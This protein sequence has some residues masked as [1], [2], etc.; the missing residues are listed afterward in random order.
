MFEDQET[1]L[2]T[3]EKVVNSM[4]RIVTKKVMIDGIESAWTEGP[5]RSFILF[6]VDHERHTI[7]FD[8]EGRDVPAEDFWDLCLS[9]PD[10]REEIKWAIF[11]SH[12]VHPAAIT[13]YHGES[14]CEDYRVRVFHCSESN[15]K[16]FNGKVYNNLHVS[17]A[18]KITP[19][20]EWWAG[21]LALVLF[22]MHKFKLT[23]NC[24]LYEDGD[25]IRFYGKYIKLISNP[26]EIYENVTDILDIM[27]SSSSSAR[28]SIKNIR[29]QRERR[30]RR[31]IDFPE[32][33]PIEEVE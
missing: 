10:I 26:H 31:A 12:R 3:M 4:R 27:R 21:D 5:G 33:E 19:R 7:N 29:P 16:F 25:I 23:R 32:I 20:F 18:G 24:A 28:N 17:S 1:S 14:G 11:D 6:K 15:I 2:K 22:K 13:I 30:P 8:Y 9:D